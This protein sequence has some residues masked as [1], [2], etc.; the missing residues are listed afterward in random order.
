[1]PA[2]ATGDLRVDRIIEELPPDTQKIARALRAVIRKDLP[3]LSETLA[4]GNPTY[5]GASRVA[6]FSAHTGYVN[7]YLFRG[8]ELA[9]RFP[10]VEGTGKALRHVRLNTP[11]DAES[12]KT[13][14]VLKAAASLDRV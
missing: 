1:M 9:P 10:Q 14:Q 5:V 13:R 6:S 4:W 11:A 12:P 3:S 8:A 7:L 2:K